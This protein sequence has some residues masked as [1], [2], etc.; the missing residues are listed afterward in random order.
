MAGVSVRETIA[1]WHTTVHSGVQ[2]KKKKRKKKERLDA[3]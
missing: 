2:K 3:A 1:L